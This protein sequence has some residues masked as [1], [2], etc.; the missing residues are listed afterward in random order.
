MTDY[1]WAKA[2]PVYGHITMWPTR[3]GHLFRWYDESGALV[4]EAFQPPLIQFVSV[5]PRPW[6]RFW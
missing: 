1:S 5:E 4:R 6:W 2:T 3:G